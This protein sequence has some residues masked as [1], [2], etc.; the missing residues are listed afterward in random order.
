LVYMM[1]QRTA[2][3]NMNVFFASIRWNKVACSS[4]SFEG[5]ASS[6][7]HQLWRRLQT[8]SACLVPL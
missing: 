5:V 7:L 3:S 6:F 8:T 2:F 4:C 1:V